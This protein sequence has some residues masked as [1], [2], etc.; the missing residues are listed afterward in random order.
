MGIFKWSDGRARDVLSEFREGRFDEF[1][2]SDR[3]GKPP[4]K[5]SKLSSEGSV[6][7]QSQ[8]VSETEKASDGSAKVVESV[9]GNDSL[10]ESENLKNE[11]RGREFRRM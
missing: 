11:E 7:V 10:S 2:L 4:A 8:R 9:V 5:K 3:T 6:E 1:V